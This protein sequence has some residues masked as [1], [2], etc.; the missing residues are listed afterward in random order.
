M[1]LFSDTPDRFFSPSTLSALLAA[2]FFMA[3]HGE[4]L[5]ANRLAGEKS[6]YLL[7]HAENP[8]DWYPWSEEAFNAARASDKP[9]LL[10]VGYS[11]CHWCNVMEEES[12]SDPELAKLLNDVFISIKVDR[13]ERPDIDRMAMDACQTLSKDCGWPLTIFMT[14][15]KKPFYA[16]AYFPKESRFGQTGMV[17]LSERIRELWKNERTT[18]L[19]SAAKIDT[20]IIARNERSTTASLDI[21]LF[22]RSGFQQLSSRFDSEHGGFGDS[23]KF[24]RPT[25]LFFLLRYFQQTGEKSSL[26]MVTKTLTAMARGGIH[27]HLGGGF[28]RYT[29]DREWRSPHFE[30]ML[31]DQALLLLA[32]SEAFQVTGNR[33]FEK[34]AQQISGYVFDQLTTK[35][36]AFAA[37]ESADSEGEEGKFYLWSAEEFKKILGS[38]APGAMAYFQVTEKGNYRDP[39]TGEETGRNVLYLGSKPAPRNMATISPKLL[40]A[41]NKRIRP[42][43]DDKILTDW[44]GLMIAALARSGRVFSQ[45]SH[46]KAA[47]RA[48]DFILTHITDKEGALLHRWRDNEAGISAGHADYAALIWG[49]I[50]L[51]GAT[52]DI[53]YLKHALRLTEVSDGLFWD[54]AKK[55]YLAFRNE[56]DPALARVWE[57]ED[58]ILPAD[59]GMTLLN[60]LRLGRLTGKTG[61]EEKAH[62]LAQGV[63]GDVQQY[64]AASSMLLTA[65][66]FA[67]GP[68]QEIVVVGKK[69][70]KD[71]AKMLKALNSRFLPNAVVV[72][73]DSEKNDPELIKLAPYIEYM[74]ALNNR[75]TVY[76]CSDYQ[77]QFPTNDL[78]KM[79]E[80][81]D[82]SLRPQEKPE[83]KDS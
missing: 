57:T 8:V 6:P 49:M 55:I 51:Y 39:A 69:E 53:R 79:D 64:P 41:R 26:D 74:S 33:E 36:G 82:R 43:K 73:K 75:A 68:T 1:R 52:F 3:V 47:Q 58:R 45:P 20:D 16:G 4:G 70:G 10:S 63:A 71:T 27:D 54:P 65:M 18:L 21:P 2:L 32:Y 7:K 28:H 24:P 29:T 61:L 81:L 35:T 12:F 59:N 62:L 34:T 38:N 9:I 22:A 80:L 67:R 44:N 19:E 66:D 72:F 25:S 14:P 78:R 37:A 48:A 60:L 40:G 13:E 77:C 42:D 23:A 5:A 30:K 31:Y 11:T 76:V 83:D 15:D 50:E 17:D 46:I 56:E